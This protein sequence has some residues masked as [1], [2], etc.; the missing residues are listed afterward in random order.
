MFIISAPTAKLAAVMLL[1]DSN[2]GRFIPRDFV[3][4]SLGALDLVHCAKWG[5]TEANR[6]Q[7]EAAYDP[8]NECYW[9]AWDWILNNAEFVTEEGDKFR[10]HQDGDL[11]ALC[12]DRMSQDEKLN[13]GFDVVDYC[14]DNESPEEDC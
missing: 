3:T 11:W 14:R 12:Y 9:E 1:L 7:W 8:E 6:E 2:R 10:L 13:F 4:D 5:L